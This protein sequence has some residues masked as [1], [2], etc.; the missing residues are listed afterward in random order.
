EYFKYHPLFNEGIVVASATLGQRNDKS[1][2]VIDRLYTPA[3][4]REEYIKRTKKIYIRNIDQD[5][6]NAY[7]SRDG[8]PI[9]DFKNKLQ[10][11]FN[12]SKESGH[13]IDSIDTE[14][15]IVIV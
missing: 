11:G 15:F 12:N 6:I 14:N 9:Y 10:I 13:L 3:H 2:L 5:K 8:I 4:Y 1:Q 7:L